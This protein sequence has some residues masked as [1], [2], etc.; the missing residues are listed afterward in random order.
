MK[1]G[2]IVQVSGFYE[3]IGVSTEKM[4]KGEEMLYLDEGSIFLTLLSTG[5]IVEWKFI[6]EDGK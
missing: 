6:S 3:I 4:I 2:E 5:E 1:S